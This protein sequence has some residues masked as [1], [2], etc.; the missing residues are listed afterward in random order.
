MASYAIHNIKISF[1][2]NQFPLNRV[3]ERIETLN[4]VDKEKIQLIQYPN[5]VVVKGQ[6]VYTI[7]RAGKEKRNHVN[8]TKIRSDDQVHACVQ[9]LENLL[10]LQACQLRIDNYIGGTD[11]RMH[12][13]FEE[14]LPILQ[15]KRVV[16]SYNLEKFPALYVYKMGITSV[17]F[18]S[19]KVQLL[20]SR[21]EEGICRMVSYLNDLLLSVSYDR[22]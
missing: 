10:Q 12:L 17:L 14:I 2:V 20:G 11:M 16:Y 4:Q 22:K 18:P 8:A 15:E 3:K 5:F 19:G 13:R 7:F 6:Y 1:K 21:T 9:Y